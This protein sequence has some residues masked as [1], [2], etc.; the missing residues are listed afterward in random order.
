MNI[1]FCYS[2]QLEF[3]ENYEILTCNKISLF[4]EQSWD[5][6]KDMEKA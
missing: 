4:Q 1:Y 3:K 6:R 5:S 2:M